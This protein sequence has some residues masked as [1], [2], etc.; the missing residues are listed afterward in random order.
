MEWDFSEEEGEYDD[1]T[2]EQA[3]QLSN[4]EQHL[5]LTRKPALKNH[6]TSST[7]SSIIKNGVY[8]FIV[9]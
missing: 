7:E 3:K 4:S 8:I 2:Q 5:Q 6:F 1:E 9:F